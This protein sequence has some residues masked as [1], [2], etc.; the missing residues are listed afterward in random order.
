MRRKQSGIFL[1]SA[2]IAVAVVGALITFWGVQQARQMRIE[3]AERIGE[4]LKAIGNA[5]ETFTVKHHGE[6]DKLLSGKGGDALQINGVEFRRKVLPDNSVRLEN[7]NATTLIQ[8][9]RLPGVSDKPPPGVGQYEIH[10]DRVCEV[11]DACRIETLTFLTEPIR[12]TYSSDADINMSSI[13]ARK[14]GTYGGLST[15]GNPGQIRFID[16]AEGVLPIVNP[17][18]GVAGLLAMRG[19]SQTKDLNNTVSRDGSRA[20]SGDLN[21]ADAEAKDASND[22]IRHNIAGVGNIEG[23]GNLRMGSLDVGAD[24]NFNGTL[25]LQSKSDIVGAKDIE[26]SGKLSMQTVT[27]KS[28]TVGALSADEKGA[29]VSGQ[30]QMAGNDIDDAKKVS[31]EEVLADSVRSEKLKAMGG[32]VEFDKDNLAIE[33]GGCSV[34]GI[35]LD[36]SG[37]VLSCQFRNNAWVWQ[38]AS[39]PRSVTDVPTKLVE[40]ITDVA[41][42]GNQLWLAEIPV[43]G[44]RLDSS[45][46]NRVHADNLALIEIK[47]ALGCSDSR[48]PENSDQWERRGHLYTDR[49]WSDGRIQFSNYFDGV[50]FAKD[51]RALIN[52]SANR[53]RKILCLVTRQENL[54][55]FAYEPKHISQFSIGWI[56]HPGGQTKQR[57]IEGIRSGDSGVKVIPTFHGSS[58]PD[59]MRQINTMFAG[60][61]SEIWDRKDVIK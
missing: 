60:S 47:G 20:M 14:I 6:I 55:V 24:A 22:P 57:A 8:A 16:Q 12:Q 25:N 42:Q 11:K 34:N 41:R 37:R 33:G 38:L 46:R 59:F 49:Y 39:M 10:V 36:T 40:E 2:A 31:A 58:S 9:L 21:F 50:S 19:G 18:A 54:S 43:D 4:S 26:G 48:H 15:S 35:S 7:L 30:L 53:S 56:S 3:R 32:I 17:K 27:A 29:M 28:A 61:P 23:N 44:S 52:T 1:V 51:A 45:G 5:V 13:A